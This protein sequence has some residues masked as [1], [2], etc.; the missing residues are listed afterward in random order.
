MRTWPDSKSF[1]KVHAYYALIDID[2]CSRNLDNCDVNADCSNEDG[3]FTCR[4]SNGWI[5]NG[6]NC[7]N[8]DECTV[9]SHACDT[10]AECIDSIGSYYC[11]CKE[12]YYGDGWS[13]C[14]GKQQTIK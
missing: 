8:E 9:P 14:K 4:C 11:T 6:F 10:N 5:G 3:Y 12:G 7:T 2:E 13:K 1:K